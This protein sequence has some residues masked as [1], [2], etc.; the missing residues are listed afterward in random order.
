[1]VQPRPWTHCGRV[2]VVVIIVDGLWGLVCEADRAACA[3]WG[4]AAGAYRGL[5]VIVG[6]AV[7]EDI[8]Q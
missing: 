8:V 7:V 3:C 1:M 4:H 6:D 2:V 5:T